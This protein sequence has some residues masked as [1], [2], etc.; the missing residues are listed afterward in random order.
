[1]LELLAFGYSKSFG[2]LLYLADHYFLE[3]VGYQAHKVYYNAC[4]RVQYRYFHN[5][6]IPSGY[7]CLIL[8]AIR[9]WLYHLQKL[10]RKVSHIDSSWSEFITS[11]R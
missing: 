3:S 5:N 8:F 9:N 2:Y 7:I 1:M 11:R 4:L 10:P 6:F